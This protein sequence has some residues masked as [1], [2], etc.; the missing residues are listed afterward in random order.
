M[1]IY[2]DIPNEDYNKSQQAIKNIPEIVWGK[3]Q[4]VQEELDHSIYTDMHA[5]WIIPVHTTIWT[6]WTSSAAVTDYPIHISTTT[7]G[8]NL[9]LDLWGDIKTRMITQMTIRPT[10][11]HLAALTMKELITIV[12]ERETLQRCNGCINSSASNPT[13]LAHTCIIDRRYWQKRLFASALEYISPLKFKRHVN[14]KARDRGI[15]LE[16]PYLLY[17]HITT[18]YKETIAHLVIDRNTNISPDGH[19]N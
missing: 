6:I 8:I 4:S 17:H 3:L 19:G 9:N 13:T 7:R 10:S 16:N 14:R 12:I 5:E 11:L 18:N 2:I 15:I 1:S